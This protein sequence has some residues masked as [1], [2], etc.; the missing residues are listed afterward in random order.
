M[1]DIADDRTIDAFSPAIKPAFV[2]IRNQ[3]PSIAEEKAKLVLQLKRM[4]DKPPQHVINGGIA[5][6]RNWVSAAAECRKVMRA[7]VGDLERAINRMSTWTNGAP[8]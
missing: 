3:R 2:D 1:K 7:S 6:V 5:T 8:T 4:V